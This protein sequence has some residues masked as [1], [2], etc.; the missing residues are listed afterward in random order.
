MEGWHHVERGPHFAQ[1]EGLT[2]GAWQ[3]RVLTRDPRS[4]P[5]TREMRVCSRPMG[6]HIEPFDK[7]T[8]FAEPISLGSRRVRGR[9]SVEAFPASWKDAGGGKGRLPA[10]EVGP[11]EIRG[12]GCHRSLCNQP[13][14]RHSSYGGA[15]RPRSMQ[16]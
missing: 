10:I 4:D 3:A 8:E 2:R 14:R 15:A 13:Q 9:S 6:Q 1:V 11:R 7:Q 5:L 12:A 16:S